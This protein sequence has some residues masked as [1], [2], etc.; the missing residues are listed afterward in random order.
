MSSSRDSD[1]RQN[2][3][4]RRALV[5]MLIAF[6]AGI[7]L[8]LS[9]EISRL[10]AA[11]AGGG[12]VTAWLVGRDA[13]EA[14]SL[15]CLLFFAAAPPLWLFRTKRIVGRRAEGGWLSKWFGDR[16]K[17][18]SPAD[19]W[20]GWRAWAAALTVAATSLLVSY[21]IASM[22][23]PG[24]NGPRFGDLPPAF[25]DEYSYLFQAKTFL[26][27]RLSFPGHETMPE[28]F[29]QMHVV[30]V[31]GHF[32]SRYFPGAGAWMAPF[33]ALGN[34]YW[35]Q[36][37]AG[38]VLAAFVF[39]IGRELGGN[40]VG[41]LAGMLTALSPGMGLFSNLLLAHHPTL[42]GLTLFAL[43][44]L[45][46]LRTKKWGYALW[47]GIGL[48]FAML[49]R[50][51][52]AAGFAFPFGLWLLAWLLRERFPTPES[53]AR[54]RHFVLAMAVPLAAGFVVLLVMNRA[55]TGSLWTSPYQLYTDTYTPRH[56][57][58]F[59]N[60]VRGEQHL[61]PRVMENYDQ[62]AENLTP[63]LAVEN[64]KK[65]AI[66][67][68]QWTLGVIPLVCGAIVFV[69]AVPA[70][71]RRWWLLPASILSLHAVHVPYW[72]VGIMNW[73]YVFETGP[74][75]LLM[76]A[77]ATQALVQYCRQSGRPLMTWWW[78]G[79][80]AA[81]LLPTFTSFA[82]VWERSRVEEAVAEVGFPRSRYQA[83]QN[84]VA[85][86]VGGKRALVLVVPDPA[87]RSI[88]FVVNAPTLDVDVLI[89]RE[90]PGTT[91]IDA[92][93]RDFPDRALYRFEAR[94]NVNEWRVVPM[95]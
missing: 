55:V 39:W 30:N 35:A 40:S 28:L 77:G 31:N 27:G 74:L 61:G 47:A 14:Q 7:A 63:S 41:F 90:R 44:F 32:A 85:R 91:D 60:R 38:A 82:P 33:L 36:W 58:G 3:G 17:P 46:M 22:P 29:D 24:S 9:S 81:T 94:F 34:P 92:V 79:F 83:F 66:A 52:T 51:M 6:L 71:D 5:G 59:N 16:S 45:R 62:W 12:G 20:A 75:W 68:W 1:N 50:P 78:S 37:L 15:L 70:G 4:S 2:R 10:R 11:A 18:I 72:F 73:H 19:D 93:R 87:D 76:F 86:T 69:C 42:M 89:A 57:Y 64:V 25:H 88:D 48:A 84:L 65:R 8:I 49:S 67:T 26:A 54:R 95:R 53:P 56:V 43:T 80:V 21:K 13:N 23:L